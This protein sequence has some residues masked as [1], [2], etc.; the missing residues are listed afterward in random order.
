MDS[1]TEPPVRRP[2]LVSRAWVQATVLVI[3]LGFFVLGLLAYRTYKA[4]PPIPD[5]VVASGGRTL[6]TGEDIRAG[7]QVFL[8][9]GLMEYGSIFGHG[10]YLSPDYTVSG[11]PASSTTRTW[12]P[13]N[14]RRGSTSGRTSTTMSAA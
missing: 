3:L 8:Q 14:A 7:Q 13:G 9:N 12:T 2:L 1:A 5:R 11:P 4:E 6:F 10:A